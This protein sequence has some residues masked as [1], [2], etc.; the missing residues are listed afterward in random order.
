M[1]IVGVVQTF[2]Y[3]ASGLR[4]PEEQLYFPFFEGTPRGGSLFVRS[5]VES[6]TA[7]AAIR[8]TVARLDPALPLTAL[9]TIDDQLDRA[10]SNER[11][12]AA[13]AVAFAALALLLAAVGLYGVT[14]FVVAGRT[15][16][17]GIRMALGATRGAA[18]W[19]VVRDTSRLVLLG[20]AVAL[21]CAWGLGRLVESQL[22]GVTALD[23]RTLAVGALV[24][25]LAAL[26]AAA[27]P[28]RRASRLDPVQALRHS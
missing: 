17:I 13:L 8:A 27:V 9:R 20:V 23:G 26:A 10:L 22:F 6:G 1:E 4:E 19:M 12:L 3:R 15:R 25:S 5:R 11:L 28:A 16:E 2:S 7:M 24:V 14:S 21:P 18:S